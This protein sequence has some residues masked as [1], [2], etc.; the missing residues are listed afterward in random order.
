[1]LLMVVVLAGWALIL[2]LSVVVSSAWLVAAKAGSG[3]AALFVE[4]GEVA[5]EAGDAKPASDA[6]RA[7]RSAREGNEGA[8]N[9]KTAGPVRATLIPWGI[10][11]WS[12]T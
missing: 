4:D 12:T 10:I 3:S 6:H 9:W 1:M 2:R 8:V 11:G 5:Q 7:R